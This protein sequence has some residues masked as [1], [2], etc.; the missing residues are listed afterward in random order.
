[1]IQGVVES[2]EIRLP[3]KVAGAPG[4]EANLLAVLDTGFTG[5]LSLP[6]DIIQLLDL[7]WDSVARGTLADGSHC[8]FDV[9]EGRIEWDGVWL[10]VFVH[11][12]DTTPL[13]GMGLLVGYE[14]TVKVCHQGMVLIQPLPDTPGTHEETR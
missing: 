12:T 7:E 13:V 10:P 3:I 9:Y 8:F 1:M 11:E 4:Q 6:V 14:L 5:H 2:L